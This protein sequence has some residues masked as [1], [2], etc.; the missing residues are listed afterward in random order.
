MN[1]AV[2]FSTPSSQ[3][4]HDRGVELVAEYLSK[5]LTQMP[6]KTELPRWSFCL[7]KASR[8]TDS[9][10]PRDLKI[11]L[12][13]GEPVLLKVYQISGSTG[14]SLYR[15]IAYQMMAK[16]RGLNYLQVVSGVPEAELQD[17]LDFH[18]QAPLRTDQLTGVR[19]L[20]VLGRFIQSELGLRPPERP[21][22]F[23]F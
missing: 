9:D 20:F 17:L 11:R 2:R 15:S 4:T 22:H 7:D 6:T 19:H 8:I 10:L 21:A 23:P 16:H 1:E 3:A 5:W 14:S 18:D 12:G 13:S